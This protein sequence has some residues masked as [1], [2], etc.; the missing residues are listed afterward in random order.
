M[1]ND[2]MTLDEAADELGVG[3][4]AILRYGEKGLLTITR[5][6]FGKNKYSVSRADV[7][8]LKNQDEPVGESGAT[9]KGRGKGK[10]K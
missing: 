1:N 8:Q 4:N 10:G 2:T 6:P 3:R 9:S 7:Q 5:R